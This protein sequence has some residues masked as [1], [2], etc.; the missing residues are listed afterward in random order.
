MEAITGGPGESPSAQAFARLARETC[1]GN[2]P[3]EI[4][5]GCAALR[6]EALEECA[7][8]ALTLDEA[9][10]VC[11]SIDD[12]QDRALHD[13]RARPPGSA[14]AREDGSGAARKLGAALHG[15]QVLVETSPLP[16]VSLD[17]AGLVG[18]WNRAA[19]EL[20]G[21]RRD[22]VV[23]KPPACVPESRLEEARRV[24]GRAH[25]GA[26][27]RDREVRWLRKDGT[28]LDL[29]LS[30]GPLRNALGEV[31]GSISILADIT[32]RKQRERETEETT[33]FRE[34]FVGVVGHDLRNPLTAIL[35]SAQLLLRY[36]RLDEAQARVVNR[37]ASSA[38]R[39]ARM[40][41]DLLDFART[42]LGG[43]F[44]LQTQRT[45]LGELTRQTVEE[46]IFAH[47]ERTVRI[48][49]AGDLWGDWDASRMEQVISNLVSNALQHGP[50][51][52][53]VKVT[54]RG[55]PSVVVFS[56]H[57]GG[58]P[59]PREVLPHV[60]EPGRRGDA[61]PGG[62]GLGLFIVQ[63]IVLAHGGS[64]E[65]HSSAAQGTTFTAVL[66]RKARAKV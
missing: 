49:A 9:R 6:D 20:F 56:T 57:N 65:A 18:I 11:R 33:R 44:P 21:W 46:L 7:R 28:E 45:D 48:D 52:G 24:I 37:V 66:P 53:E 27:I 26:V 35:A 54:V 17:R 59:I 32:G 19:E 58:P 30:V 14:A 13:A 31:D 41:A 64:I 8:G 36:G 42:R 43:G 51:D 55:E 60:F 5:R 38:G 40:I 22:E 23:G 15:F 63:Q 1:A 61:Q 10:A 39:M 62:L 4:A 29:S 16:I 50:E 25:E 47:P 3:V 12:A 2:D 34:H